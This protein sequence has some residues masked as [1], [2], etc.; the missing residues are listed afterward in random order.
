MPTTDDNSSA[1]ANPETYWSYWVRLSRSLSAKLILVMLGALVP[2]F[3]LLGY[4]SLRLH[5]SHLERSTLAAAERLSDVIKRSASYSMMHNDREGMHQLINTAGKE[6]GIVRIRIINNEGMIAYSTDP[7][8]LNRTINPANEACTGCHADQQIRAEL[9]NKERFRI[10]RVG[11]GR[12]LGIITPIEN[13]PSCSNA[14]CHAHKAEQKILGVLDTSLSLDRA[15]ANLRESTRQMLFCVIAGL[16]AM[17]ALV[18]MFVW[19]FVDVPVR[20]LIDGTQKLGVGE[21]GFQIS[22]GSNDEL[23]ELAESF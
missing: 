23:G 11:D 21:L 14:E 22:V 3:A 9:K 18:A 19:R 16:I 1:Q 10:F 12:V 6:P 7:H 15:D 4:A 17:A 2:I 8:E 20:R 13:Q 5:R